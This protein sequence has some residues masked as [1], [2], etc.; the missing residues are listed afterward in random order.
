MVCRPLKLAPNLRSLTQET[1]SGS[2]IILF[3]YNIH[4]LEL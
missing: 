3:T 1:T 2:F 4:L